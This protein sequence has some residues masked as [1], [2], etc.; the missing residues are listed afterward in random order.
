MSINWDNG[1][2]TQLKT[3]E[4]LTCHNLS[5]GQLYAMYFYN[6]NYNDKTVNVNVVWS[7][8]QPPVMVTV[9]GTTGD[10][11]L[12]SLALVSGD[13]TQ[14][15]AASI[16]STREAHLDCWLCSVGMPINDPSLTN[17]ELPSDGRPHPFGGYRRYYKVLPAS[18]NQITLE[19]MT[20]EFILAQFQESFITILVANPI[21]SVPRRIVPMGT[22]AQDK[23]YK[24]VQPKPG[25]PAQRITYSIQGDGTQLVWMSADSLKNPGKATINLQ[26]LEEL[27]S[28][29]RPAEKAGRL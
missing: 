6:D 8:S 15:V 16:T 28:A 4:T 25:E 1:N 17:G 27:Y 10:A 22:V 29:Y 9:P 19:S 7:N 26:S 11:G 20:T 3:G 24:I 23:D 18:W 2:R 13:D 21:Q 12:A 5:A 14:V